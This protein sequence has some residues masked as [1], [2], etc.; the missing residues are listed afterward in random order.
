ML[1]ISFFLQSS[2][3]PKTLQ[4]NHIKGVV[5]IKEIEK[6][7]TPAEASHKW[8]IKRA[9]WGHTT[10]KRKLYVKEYFYFFFILFFAIFQI[11]FLIKILN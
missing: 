9:T 1:L 10:E 3:T 8:G 11:Y 5:T 2:S 6:Y 4:Q 7:M